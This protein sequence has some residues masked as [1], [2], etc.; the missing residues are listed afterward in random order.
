[1][2]KY[3]DDKVKILIH[4]I[5]LKFNLR[6]DEVRKIVS[7][8]YKFTRDTIFSLEIKDIET[9]EEFNNLKT[10]FIY[11]YIGKLYTNFKVY[12]KIKKQKNNLTEKWENKK[13]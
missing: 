10:N 7:S 8:P 4:K 12:E 13:I 6:D 1:M 11:P 2:S 3:E 5:G 9:E